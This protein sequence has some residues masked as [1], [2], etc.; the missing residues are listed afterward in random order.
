MNKGQRKNYFYCMDEVHVNCIFFQKY[1]LTK[2]K[3]IFFNLMTKHFSALLKKIDFK[4]NIINTKHLL[5]KK[6]C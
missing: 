5:L 1:P 3:N 2:K 6:K 4:L